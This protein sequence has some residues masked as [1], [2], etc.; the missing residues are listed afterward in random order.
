MNRYTT[1]KQLGDGT[2]GSVLMGKSNESGELVAI[3]RMKRKFYSWEECMNLREVKSLKKLSHANVVKLKEV[4]RENDHLYFVF[5]YMKENLY[6]LMKDRN[7]LFPES[8]IRNIMYQILQGLSF[9]HKHGFFHRD[10]KPENLLCMGPELV[11]I[12]DF[13]LAREIRSRPPYTDYVSTRWYRAPEV[14]L[15]SSVYSSPIDMWAVGCIMAELYTLRPL[16][17]GN[18]EVDEIFKIC[19]V[20]GTVKKS[21]WPEGYQLAA[22]MSFRFPQCVPTNLKTLIPNASNEAISLMRDMLQWDPKKRPTAVQAL[23]YPYFQ[24]GQVLGPPPQYVEQQKPQVRTIQAPEPKPLSLTKSDQQPP[25]QR[26]R[27]P[28]PAPAL[29]PG[30]NRVLHQPLQQIPVPQASLHSDSH[31]QE[32]PVSPSLNNNNSP[33]KP[34]PAGNENNLVGTKSGRRRWGQTT[35]KAVDSW[36]E[37]DDSDMGVSYSKKPSIGSVKE[38][39]LQDS[40]FRHPEPKPL[41]T[42]STVIKLPSNTTTTLNRNDSETS[43]SSS[44]RQHYL[45]Q[46]RYLPGVNPKNTSLVGNK[47]SG[48]DLWGNS[49]SLMNKPLG[50]IGAELSV[51]RVNADDPKPTD[52]LPVKEKT[53][54]KVELPKGTCHFT[55]RNF[56]STNYNPSGGYVSSFQKK[57]VGSAGQRIQLAPLG[58]TSATSAWKSGLGSQIRKPSVAPPTVIPDSPAFRGM[59]TLWFLIAPP[60]GTCPHCGLCVEDLPTVKLG[61]SVFWRSS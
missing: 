58:S 7:K 16:F 32:R 19:Q 4:I 60:T 12:A 42:Y 43:N 37:F 10:M 13:G 18:S 8:V 11:K 51:S 2:Y 30:P 27:A 57:E 33:L 34:T 54:D 1:L 56:V 40:V 17:P 39:M 44:A 24:V 20:L 48:R 52:K 36:D 49:T 21:D 45:R 9:I 15:R 14:L 46:S 6:Q 35:V 5:E 59:H 31:K 23:R 41:N 38:K 47:E 50:P 29:A 26:T 28:A 25:A 3:K 61:V 22:A 53:L 55:L